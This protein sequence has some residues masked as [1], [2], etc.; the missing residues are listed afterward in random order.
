MS[1]HTPEPWVI[2]DRAGLSTN[3]Y[4]D[5]TAGSI[6][7]SCEEY[8]FA[9]RSL[10]ERKANARRIVECVNACAGMDDPEQEIQSLKAGNEKLAAAVEDTASR[11]AVL[12]LL[13]RECRPCVEWAITSGVCGEI[14]LARIDAALAGWLPDH[15]AG[16]GKMVAGGSGSRELFERWFRRDYHPDRMGPYIKDITWVAWQAALSAAPK[17]QGGAPCDTGLPSSKSD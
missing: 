9:Y 3:F 15:V 17:L 14:A 2:D 16:A 5:D 4:Q 8:K 6:I 11:N 7:G 1:Q 10:D 12:A 13:L